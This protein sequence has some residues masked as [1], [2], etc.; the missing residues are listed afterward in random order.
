MTNTLRPS[1]IEGVD[2]LS[3]LQTALLADDTGLGKS[4][5]AIRAADKIGAQRILILCPAIGRVSWGI[6][7]PKWQTIDRKV[8]VWTP[9][10]S[11]IIPPTGPVA[12]VVAYDAFSRTEEC[13]RV[14]AA[15]KR[16][17]YVDP[18]HGDKWIVILDEAH[19]LSNP[20]SN[21]TKRIYGNKLDLKTGLFSVIKAKAG[22]LMSATIQRKHAGELYPHL[23]SLFQ[24]V[25]SVLFNGII[26]N[27]R[28]FED[29]FCKVIET[30][31]GRDIVGNDDEEIP[32][33]RAA[34]KPFTLRRIKRDVAKELGEVQYL[35][36]PFS[37]DTRDLNLT[38]ELDEYF[39]AIDR[40]DIGPDT[41]IPLEA[42]AERRLLGIAKTPAA[43]D[44]INEFLT[45]NPDKKLIVFAHHRQVLDQLLG[46]CM[47]WRPA[48]IHGGVDTKDRIAAAEQFQTDPDCRLFLGQTIAAGVAIT[49]TAAHYVLVLEPE[50]VPADNYQAIS[51]AHRIGQTEPVTAF[52]AY[53]AGTADTR[54]AHRAARR[55]ADF[56]AL[57]GPLT[58]EGR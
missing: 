24:P 20:K 30:P 3:T 22:W 52:Y 34:M 46:A 29:R 23:A 49:L 35:T 57:M 36:L 38:G 39:D 55:T 31:H 42:A 28:D 9:G 26:P 2:F 12:V 27:L 54:L 50:G 37:V 7:L 13:K 44:W 58:K 5:Q 56:D 53:A 19:N 1:Q 8:I 51:R 17:E 21:R 40:G 32:A 11:N 15:L 25:L 43:I 4:V 16:V 33:L 48:V 6:E 10:V 45:D 18:N 14:F 47:G 41:P